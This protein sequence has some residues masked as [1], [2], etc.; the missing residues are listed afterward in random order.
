MSILKTLINSPD[1]EALLRGQRP[2]LLQRLVRAH[3]RRKAAQALRCLPDYLLKDMGIHRSEIGAVVRG[4]H[5]SMRPHIANSQTVTSAA[6]VARLQDLES[7]SQHEG[8]GLAASVHQDHFLH[9]GR[10][11]GRADGSKVSSGR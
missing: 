5:P 11:I 4:E 1:Q 9:E 10:A 3:R 8:R 7:V 6:S 2:G